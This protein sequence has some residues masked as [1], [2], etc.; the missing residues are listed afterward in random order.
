MSIYKVGEPGVSIAGTITV[1]NRFPERYFEDFSNGPGQW[2]TAA[3]VGSQKEVVNGVYRAFAWGNDDNHVPAGVRLHLMAFADHPY[4]MYEKPDGS[5]VTSDLTNALIKIRARTTG[6]FALTPQQ[7]FIVWHCSRHPTAKMPDG[8]T[9]KIVNW[10]YVGEPRTE[11]LVSGNWETISWRLDPDPSKWL[12]GLGH[13]GGLYDTFLPLQEALQNTLNVH[14]LVIGPVGSPIPIGAF[15]MDE[16]EFIFNR[17]DAPLAGPAWDAASKAPAVVLSEGN[18]RAAH[19]AFTVTGGVKGDRKLTGKKYWES[20]HVSG[21]VALC[22]AVGVCR[23]SYQP[24]ATFF[25]DTADG[26]AFMC[27]RAARRHGLPPSGEQPW[28]RAIAAG[29]TLRHAFDEATGSYWVGDAQG[30]FN[31]GDPET[32]A[33]P[34]YSGITGDIHACASNG[35]GNGSFVFVENFGGSPFAYAPPAGFSGL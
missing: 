12:F 22:F 2:I 32:G 5:V 7:Q 10:G 27:E 21:S 14:F 35:T 6:G 15:E 19:G 34:M 13:A 8:V 23:S 11:Q 33:N 17:N 30:W 24:G 4:W 3:P 20:T 25:G 31:G 16:A 28:G 1:P 26:W 9:P 18:L 29:A